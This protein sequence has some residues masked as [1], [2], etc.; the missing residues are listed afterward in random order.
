MAEQQLLPHIGFTPVPTLQLVPSLSPAKLTMCKPGY[1]PRASESSGSHLNAINLEGFHVGH[2][3]VILS[4]STIIILIG[5]ALFLWFWKKGNSGCCATL[6]RPPALPSTTYNQ[7]SLP[8]P[9]HYLSSAPPAVTNPSHVVGM[10]VQPTVAP[11]SM[12]SSSSQPTSSVRELEASV[13][14]LYAIVNSQ[15][16][17]LSDKNTIIPL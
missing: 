3:N 12:S 6:A 7:A 10:E 5:I 4:G 17:A 9:L 14:K 2:M 8:L 1:I 15:A 13:S 16:A 11:S